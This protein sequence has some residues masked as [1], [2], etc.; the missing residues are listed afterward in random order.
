[1]GFLIDVC[2]LTSLGICSA[3]VCCG[4]L[5]VVCRVLPLLDRQRAALWGVGQ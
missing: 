3:L 5:L 2:Y 1:M 4:A